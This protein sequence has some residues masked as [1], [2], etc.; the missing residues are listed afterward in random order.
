MKPNALLALKLK[1]DIKLR[2]MWFV[3]EAMSHPKVCGIM[4]ICVKNIPSYVLFVGRG[5]PP[6]RQWQ[7]S[8]VRPLALGRDAGNHAGIA[9]SVALD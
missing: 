5:S 2:K 6:S 9:R 7:S 3:D 4:A 1:P 8:T